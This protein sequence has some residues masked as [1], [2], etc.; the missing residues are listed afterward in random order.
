MLWIF[1]QMRIS[2]VQLATQ[3]N[4]III[5]IYRMWTSE[6]MWFDRVAKWQCVVCT[7]KC[8]SPKRKAS[9][10]EWLAIFF[11]SAVALFISLL[12][13]LFSF[14]ISSTFQFCLCECGQ[15]LLPRLTAQIF[16]NCITLH[17]MHD[18]YFIRGPCECILTEWQDDFYRSAFFF[19]IIPF[20]DSGTK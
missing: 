8:I 12:F 4:I 10:N 9:P 17:C 18:A 1:R 3:C 11:V 16:F 6:W 14:N 5:I 20:E 19:F 7:A 13:L 15:K 2:C